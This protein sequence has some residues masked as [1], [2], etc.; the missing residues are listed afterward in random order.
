MCLATNIAR[1]AGSASYYA[2]LAVPKDLQPILKKRELWKSL[3]TKDPR[4]A[5]ARVAPVLAKWHA[6]FA[7]LRRRH[8]ATPDDLQAATWEHYQQELASYQA[9]RLSLPSEA[10]IE[11]AVE[12]ARKKVQDA[13]ADD[14]PLAFI[15]LA[16]D[17]MVLKG[18]AELQR[19]FRARREKAIRK[20][21]ATGEVGLIEGLALDLIQREGWA[22]EQGSAAFRDL[23]QKLQRAELEAL[24]R[25]DEQDSG[26]FT[27]SPRDP[28]VK[29][30]R[31]ALHAV[32]APGE[33]V[34]EL[35]EVFVTEN[36]K[37]IKPDTIR[38]NR[39]IVGWFAQHVGPTFPASKIDKKSV[40]DWKQ[41]LA[42]FP[43]K[44]AEVREFRGL[45]FKKIIA[46][47]E[48]AKR[49]VLSDRTINKYLSALG[50]FCQWLMQNG[51]LDTN[52][53]DGMH[54][55][56]ERGRGKVRPYI[57]EEL[58]RIFNSPLFTGCLSEEEAH[59][60]GN[61]RLG[62]HRYWLPLLSLFTGA[63]MNELAQ[64]LVADVRQDRG[65]WIL[66]VTREGDETKTVKTKGSQRVI[67]VHP[68]LER[69]GFI[70]YHAQHAAVGD[71]RLFP[72]IKPDARGH[73]SGHFSRFWGRYVA[74]IGV[75]DDASVNFHSFRH[76]MADALRRAGYRD[77]EFGFL[78][79]HT[80]ATTTGR[81]GILSEGDLT[82]RCKMIDAVDFPGLSLAHLHHK[83]AP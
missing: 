23:C 57:A 21:L 48:K 10:E 45:K 20:H 73:L 7:D 49:P 33:S 83:C 54:L 39:E 26:D 68:E 27:G 6:E 80:Q 37:N 15:H 28:A 9:E 47:N 81:Y 4:E 1:R 29:A 24:R 31:P 18:Q 66:H 64:L 17:A 35:F 60:P 5:R 62:D 77:E 63:R 75:K 19:E 2:R 30:P 76:G 51:H 46:A 65:R 55:G 43:I 3:D 67:P 36:P 59:R 58:T 38:M 14:G 72:E 61:V 22:M 40:R 78:L 41:A 74:R 69:L 82:Q 16:G 71:R 52:P 32:A 42:K 53:V 70:A 8:E 50:A 44:A 12:H 34:M 56:K 25:Q 79:G 13:E 11:G